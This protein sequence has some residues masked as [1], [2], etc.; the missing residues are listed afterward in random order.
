MINNQTENIRLKG[1][2]AKSPITDVEKFIAEVNLNSNETVL[3]LD[4]NMVVGSLHVI[5][6]YEHAQR[7]FRINRARTKNLKLETLIYIAGTTQIGLALDKLKLK[8]GQKEMILVF[9]GNDWTDNKITGFLKSM[10]LISDDTLLEKELLKKLKN[11]GITE[12]EL[13]NITEERMVDII[14]EKV[15]LVDIL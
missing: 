3:V 10:N 15:A 1:A 14:L 13:K 2:I 4:A 8:A 7:A 11:F 9:F 6:A 5:S 12:N